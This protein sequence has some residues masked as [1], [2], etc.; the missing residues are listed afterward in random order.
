M[1]Q[2]LSAVNRAVN[3]NAVINSLLAAVFGTL[4]ARSVVQ[5]RTI[6]ALEA[7]KDALVKSNKSIQRTVW[8]WKQKLYAEAEADQQNAVVSLST[9]KSIY[10]EVVASASP[11]ISGGDDKQDGKSPAPK[12]MI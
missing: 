12:I 8:E 2:V 7:E 11:V 10:G 4:A 5:E 1:E 9:L 3:S 6:E